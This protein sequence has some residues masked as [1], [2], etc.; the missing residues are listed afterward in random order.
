MNAVPGRLLLGL[1]LVLLTQAGCF[2]SREESLTMLSQ[3]RV[4][5]TWCRLVEGAQKPRDGTLAVRI[6][7]AARRNGWESGMFVLRVDLAFLADVMD[8]GG[9]FYPE[10]AE[11]LAEVATC[12]TLPNEVKTGL[13]RVLAAAA[14]GDPK[15]VL[16]ALDDVHTEVVDIFDEAPDADQRREAAA[17]LGHEEAREAAEMLLDMARADPSGLVRA[18][19]L[20]ALGKLAHTR[21]LD[22]A[23]AGVVDPSP[24]VRQEALRLVAALR[25]SD[26]RAKVEELFAVSS[27]DVSV[28]RECARVL[29]VLGGAESVPVLIGGLKPLQDNSI[30][31]QSLYALRAITQQDFG[32]RVSLW[33]AWWK[34]NEPVG[35]DAEGERP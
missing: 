18:T 5:M 24:L 9:R 27:E 23:R 2:L 31:I 33:T 15:A 17:K 8:G 35:S 16:S 25:M 7:V 22:A 6:I 12:M 26:L 13:E 11:E 4:S 3:Y 32:L 34:E 14:A 30:R 10:R 20:R 19:C 1:V 29:G 28:R 21:S